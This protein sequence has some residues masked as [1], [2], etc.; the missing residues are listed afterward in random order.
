MSKR[1]SLNKSR[2]NRIRII[3]NKFLYMLNIRQNL[4]LN[5]HLNEQTHPLFWQKPTRA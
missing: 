4:F 1:Q 5:L 2:E 3:D